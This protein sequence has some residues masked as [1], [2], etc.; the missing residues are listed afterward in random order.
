MKNIKKIRIIE[1]IIFLAIVVSSLIVFYPAAKA[2]E[3]QLV[4][5][6]DKL[7]KTVEDEF[8][9]K[10]TYESI[11]PSFFDRIKIRD[12]T[13]YNA[14]TNEKI[15]HFSLLYI[16]YRLISLI[17][18]DFTSV[19]AS[20]GVYDGIIDF[21]IEKNKNILK[22]L[23]IEENAVDKTVKD[24][25]KDE[26]TESSLDISTIIEAGSQKIKNTKPIK[27]ELK[28]IALNYSNKNSNIDF[29]TS[30]GKLTLDSGKIDVYINSSLRYSN[31]MQTNFPDLSTL[32]NIN[33]SFYPGNMSASSILNFSDIRLGNIY[34]DKFSLFASYLDKIASITTMQ[35]IQPIDVKG[36]WNLAENAGSIN[37]ECNDLRPLS[38]V[39][40]SERTDILKELKDAAF[41]GQFNLTFAR[42]E[43]L[44]WDT[45][46]SIKLPKFQIAGNKIEKS[47]LSFKA[48]GTD[49]LINL[50][51]LK[52][53]N[54]DINL[55]AQGSYKIKEILPNFYLN[56]S[57]FKLPSGENMAM[58][59]NVS[60]NKNKIFLKIPRAD[61]GKASLENI[62][63][64]FE[65]KTGKTD[66][67]LSGKD[68]GGGFSIDGTWTH[69][70]K[71]GSSG[72]NKGYL[73]L[74]GTIDSISIENIYNGAVSVTDL[75]VPMQKLLETSI[76][77]VQMTSE[78]YISSDLEHF[79][80]NIIQAVL[81]SK[82]KNGFYSLF[83]L[84]GN[85]SSL[86]ISDIDVLF[87]NMNLRG[88]INSAFE[89]DSMIFD[90]L[91]T[92]NDISYK[93]SGLLT[94]EMI[95]IYGD[96]NLNVNILKE[97]E[98]KLKGTIQVKELP[99]PFIDSLF[100][101]DTSFE[102][103]NN[104]DWELT[105]N[106]A[107]LE[108]LGT[109]I[110][111][112]DEGLE[113]YAE[114]YAKPTE[115]FFHNV[116][117]GIKN[118]QLEGTAALNLIPS[119]DKNISQYE[120]NLSLLD[121]NKTESFIFNSL[122]TVSDKIYFDGTCNI[123]DISLNRFFKKQKPE[124]KIAAEFIFL[125]N[126]DS[127]SVKAD[128]KNI[129]FNLKGQNIEGEAS[130]FIDNDK[131]NLY[132]SSF[133][134]GIHKIDNIQAFINPS[135]QK[136]ALTFSYEAK[137]KNPKKQ[138]NSDTKAAFS[139]DFI[140]TADK[141]T[142]NKSIIEKTVNMT[143]H[144]NIDMEISDWILAGQKGEG[145]IKASLVKEPSII[146]LYAGNN[147]EIYGFKTDDGVVSLHID[148]SLPLH[149]NI[150]GILADSNINLSVSNIGIDLAKV[151][152]FIPNNNI[153]KFSGGNVQGD[154]QISGT[155][156][157]PLFYGTLKG[158]ELFC[159]SPG[160]S[161]DTYGTV[162]IPIQFDGTLISVPYTI[163]HGKV[164]SIWGEAKSEFIGWIPYYTTVDCGVLENTQGL[165][166]TKNIAFHA[167]GR[168]QGK[169]RLE[170]NPKLVTLEGDAYFDKGYFSV[171]FADLQKQ[172][173]Q[174]PTGSIVPAFYMNLNLNLG[175]KS[176]FRYPSTEFPFL[177]ALAYTENEPF[178]LILDTGLG[179]FE[180]SGAAK[181]RTGEI[182]YIKRN[183]YIKEGELK[184]LNTPF[185][186]IEP[187]IS[188]KAEIKDKMPDGQPL[189]I[190]LTAKEQHLDLER[191]RPVIT[192]SPPMAMSDSD[193][194]NLMGQV[195][196][197]DL[198]NS[199]V[200]KETLLNASDILANI[201][202]MKKL[203]QK[204][205][206][207]LHV[208]VFSVRSLLIQNVILENLFRSSKD[209][210]L[211]IGNYFDNTSVYIGKY[212]GSAIYADAMLHLSYYDP[213]SAK[214]DVVRKSVYENLLF[215]PEIGF[216][217]NTPFALLRWHIAPSNLDSL[218]VS[219]TGLTLSWKFSY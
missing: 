200:L 66:I 158:E 110:T 43:K 105:C 194:M 39:S 140:S 134:W 67:Y 91:L 215:Q 202:L 214:T 54:S 59:L 102:Y 78:F 146:A 148:E 13:I 12:V 115:V 3:K 183:F 83:S 38:V 119:S 169:I 28:N 93:V 159:T 176:E 130:A 217:M 168:A 153:I 216:E 63:G 208:D 142:E 98:K 74:H 57:K 4:Y 8:E 101:A 100:S 45:A 209:K 171:P 165:I 27:L 174:I 173:E 195:A 60:S 82:S 184:I 22:K 196:L 69:P 64:L 14:A 95:S 190:N 133:K 212:F 89:K 121:K 31:F 53:T 193:T 152:N 182:F 161:P 26:S 157:D 175:K 77:P 62:Q 36:S 113:F 23:N 126:K 116:K 129:S 87:N 49:D 33:G 124:N 156:K 139:F 48:D 206:D 47:I 135:E 219:D 213:L 1:I 20:L 90:S 218:F 160:Y 104:K 41:T 70:S 149:L 155:Q 44:L 144:F 132:E 114:G 122:F 147:D 181:I 145:S 151:I 112:T 84:Q 6:R 19:I 150:D 7:I 170:I 128:L 71:N 15:A 50:K 51:N 191:F 131:M 61:I 178:N 108:Y 11:S 117:A 120:A 167:D 32:I 201:G 203:E 16:D 211:T 99:V 94:D 81:A 204:A 141:N 75:T 164:G 29:Y 46:F 192:T 123:K 172:S 24:Q 177:R 86:N 199:N 103:D 42:P 163:L 56:V 205:R 30:S 127:L 207:V 65:K 40:S 97:A 189:T 109:D 137:T 186:Q 80:Y 118:K 25:K 58:N 96:Y 88:N 187:I 107:K 21:N 154:L 34:I 18:K 72:K 10:I 2:L 188:V 37:L 166:K 125:G 162:E 55:S 179:K 73:E 143:S 136:G 5:V 92:L 85:E 52:L 79:S 9:I 68:P 138:E 210:P 111:K 76:A 197:G 198:K 106:Y 185:Q 17:K 35:D 180:M